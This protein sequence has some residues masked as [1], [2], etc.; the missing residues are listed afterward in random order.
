MVTLIGS[1]AGCGTAVRTINFGRS[2]EERVRQSGPYHL[3][4]HPV[5]A[6]AILSRRSQGRL[7]HQHGPVHDVVTALPVSST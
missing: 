1:F 2:L 6:V 4:L 3:D 7:V 5:S